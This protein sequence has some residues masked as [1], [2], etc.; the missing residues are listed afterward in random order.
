M[1]M[2]CLPVSAQLITGT[3]IQIMDGIWE[4][5]HH[6][7]CACHTHSYTFLYVLRLPRVVFLPVSHEAL[8]LQRNSILISS[9]M[10]R[11][12]CMSTATYGLYFL[13]NNT[14][15]TIRIEA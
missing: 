6:R 9:K 7:F 2:L 3:L 8:A 5:N 10:S 15:K 14:M 13:E 11:K 1:Y 12:Y 4:A